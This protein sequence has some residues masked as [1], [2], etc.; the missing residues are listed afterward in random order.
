LAQDGQR[1]AQRMIGVMFCHGLGVK[2]NDHK[3]VE[4]YQKA[5]VDYH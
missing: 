2:Q 1:G 4:W 5:G 3:A